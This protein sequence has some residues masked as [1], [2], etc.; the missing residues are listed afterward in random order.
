MIRKANLVAYFVYFFFVQKD[1]VS[2]TS[3]VSNDQTY[4]MKSSNEL[5]KYIYIY[6]ITTL[7]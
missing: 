7:T 6:K 2:K 5:L 3:N 4:Q 1:R